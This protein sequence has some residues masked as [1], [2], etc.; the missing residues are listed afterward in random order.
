MD[1]TTGPYNRVLPTQPH[2]EDSRTAVKFVLLALAAALV[3]IA[4]AAETCSLQTY[5]SSWMATGTPFSI[6]CPSGTYS[7]HLVSTPARRFF[8]RGH[9]MLVFD[10]PVV[11][12]A[13]NPH[14][15]G[16]IQ[17]GRGRQIANMLMTGGVSIGSKDLS[18][19]ISGAVFKSWYMIPISAVAIS[20]FSTGGDVLLKPGYKLQVE[21]RTPH[22]NP[23]A[24]GEALSSGR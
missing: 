1:P 13:K 22:T 6:K 12:I 23:V 18:D 5:A 10:Q 9:L 2:R 8:R 14:D 21:S 3:P 4:A 16:K 19:G 15:E 20:F 24:T 17:P 11:L 7:G